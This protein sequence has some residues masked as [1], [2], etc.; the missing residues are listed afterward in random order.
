M[1]KRIVVTGGTGNLGQPVVERLLGEGHEVIC[2]RRPDDTTT[3][4]GLEMNKVDLTKESD[5][6]S[7][8]E[9]WRRKYDRIDGL[10]CMAGGF[11]MTDLEATGESELWT[12]TG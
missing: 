6:R 1:S 3:I 10:L 7:L 2:T 8:V 11:A 5:V 4:E 9:I 12:C